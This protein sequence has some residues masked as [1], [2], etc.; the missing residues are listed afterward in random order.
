MSVP[1]LE[2]GDSIGAL[3][4]PV[5]WHTQILSR[6]YNRIDDPELEIEISCRTERNNLFAARIG[7]PTIGQ[8]LENRHGLHFRVQSH[9]YLPNV[10]T[11]HR[12]TSGEKGLPE[13][14]Y[15]VIEPLN[16]SQR[17][18]DF[19]GK[20]DR[21]TTKVFVPVDTMPGYRRDPVPRH[22][23]L[24]SA[25][26]HG[27]LLFLDAAT[28]HETIFAHE[29]GHAWLQYVYECED[30]RTLADIS[31]PARSNQVNFIQSYVLDLKVNELLRRKGFDMEPIDG[32]QA[33]A[34][35]NL[36]LL[37]DS[38]FSPHSKR[39][40]VLGAL[41]FAEQIVEHERGNRP[42]LIRFDDALAKLTRFEPEIYKLATKMAEAV[43]EFGMESKAAIR[44]A[45]DKCLTLA[46]E[47]T[48]DPLDLET[49]LVVPPN[50]EPNFDKW[51]DWIPGANVRSKCQIGRVMA[52]HDIPDDSTWSL[53]CDR[54]SG[55][56]LTFQLSDG[57]ILGPWHVSTPYNAW[58]LHQMKELD[59][60]NREASNRHSNLIQDAINRNRENEERRQATIDATTRQATPNSPATPRVPSHG[61][62]FPT[63]IPGRRPYMAG[64]GR[65]LTEARLAERLAGEHPY[66]Y[67]LNSPTTYTD[68]TGL[69]VK[70]SGHCEA[71]VITPEKGDRLGIVVGPGGTIIR[72]GEA[73][74]LFRRP[75]ENCIAV[76][77]GFFGPG[78]PYHPGENRWPVGHVTDC[79]GKVYPDPKLQK[80]GSYS[81]PLLP[82][83]LTGQGG[84]TY[85]RP[86]SEPGGAGAGAV[87]RTGACTDKNGNLV[88][89]VVI[90]RVDFETFESCM[91]KICPKGSTIVLLDGGGSSQIVT[92]P[93]HDSGR[94]VHNW[95]VICE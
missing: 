81:F 71:T 2:R 32:D 21:C 3:G 26:P 85:G 10:N 9:V 20:V 27:L 13:D 56:R 31:D 73:I 11:A 68:P 92:S 84:R 17:F 40:A 29:V 41:Q 43:F 55:A 47:F 28:L 25:D 70:K 94:P 79:H 80:G 77:A 90:P 8:E 39:E 91:K 49:D 42:D 48:G 38:G 74:R 88:A 33:I 75:R 5:L 15:P 24:N 86:P 37:L 66:G 23:F 14:L 53:S 59:K 22:N 63:H 50:E 36:S 82:V 64:L 93:T 30:E 46:F 60:M 72:G 78:G 18:M 62:P 12:W 69:W 54:I 61:L 1:P 65:F 58:N 76:N 95:I 34:M 87:T 51:P 16:M 83:I 44:N 57:S 89:I 45:I 7:L 52:L 4:K 19:I 6:V 67:A 35:N